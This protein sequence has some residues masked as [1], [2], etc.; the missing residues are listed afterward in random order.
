MQSMN[1]D[2]TTATWRNSVPDKDAAEAA[3]ALQLKLQDQASGGSWDDAI[4]KL[5]AEHRLK[6]A[7]DHFPLPAAFNEAAIALRTLIGRHMKGKRDPSA[8][9]KLLYWISAVAS[10]MPPRAE[11]AQTAGFSVVATI[12]GTK[13]FGLQFDWKT[14]G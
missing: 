4:K 2:T 12:P 13:L 6:V 8:S 11:K 14:L 3:R 5:P 7:I 9:L 10:F 1:A